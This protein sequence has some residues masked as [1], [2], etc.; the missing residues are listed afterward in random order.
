MPCLTSYLL[1]NLQYLDLSDNLLTDM[2]L[3]ETLCDGRSPLRA[4]RV[5]NVSG[6]ALKVGRS[7]C[8]PR[9]GP[10][11]RPQLLV[12]LWSSPCPAPAGCWPGSTG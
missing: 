5:L 1:R 10:W 2:T 9:S 6:N 4:L 12:R 8:P 11:T 7:A 3:T